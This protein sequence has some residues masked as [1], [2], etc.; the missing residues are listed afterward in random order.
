MAPPIQNRKVP[1]LEQTRGIQASEPQEPDLL[2]A[3]DLLRLSVGLEAADDL[4]AD[5]EQALASL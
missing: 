4:I 3:D 2:A 1:M 5:L